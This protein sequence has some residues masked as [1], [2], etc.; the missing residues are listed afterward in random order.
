MP[1]L[2]TK[3]DAGHQEYVNWDPVDPFFI[4]D[5]E[6]RYRLITA[7]SRERETQRN[8]ITQVFN[9]GLGHTAFCTTDG[10]GRGALVHIKL[11]TPSE[12]SVNL[13]ELPENT[14]VKFQ[15][16]QQDRTYEEGD[17]LMK[18]RL[19]EVESSADLVIATESFGTEVKPS[20]NFQIVTVVQP[21]TM[22][23]DDQLNALNEVTN[24]TVY[25]SPYYFVLDFKSVS[26]LESHLQEER[27]GHIRRLFPLD[28]VQLQAFVNSTSRVTCGVSLNQGPPGTGKTRTAVAIILALT[29]L[30]IKV[31]V[32]A[33]SNK[34]VDNLLESLVTAA[35][36]DAL[37]RAWCDQFVR[38]G[39]PAYQ[40]SQIRA[41]S[42]SDPIARLRAQADATNDNQANP[43]L[44][45]VQAHNLV[46]AHAQQNPDDKH[47]KS[48]LEYMAIDKEKGLSRDGTKK[49]RSSYENT[50]L[51][52]FEGCIVVATTL[53]N[54]SH[55][56]LR[57]PNF[58][59]AFIVSDEAGQCLEGDHC[60]A[61]TM[62]SV[63][64]VVLIGDPDQ[65]SPTTNYRNHSQILDLFNSGMYRG[66]LVPGPEND[67]LERV[68]RAWDSFTGPR[69][70]F[71]ALNVHG[72]RRLFISIIGK[73]KRME[74]SLPWSN[75][76]QV[77][78]LHHLLTSL[79][80]FQTSNGDSVLPEDVMIV[81]PYKDQ[82]VLVQRILS[83]HEV[84]YRDNLTVD[85]TQGQE[86]PIVMFLMTKP[87]QNV[88][89]AG[90]MADTNRLNIV[91]SRAKKVMI[92]IGNL[93]D[94]NNNGI[95]KMKQ[96]VGKR[97]RFLID[98]IRDVTARRHTLTW[99]G[100]EANPTGRVQYFS[101][102][103]PGD[104]QDVPSGPSVVAPPTVR[105]APFAPPTTTLPVV[106]TRDPTEVAELLRTQTEEDHYVDMGDAPRVLA[107]N[108]RYTVQLPLRQRSCSP[109]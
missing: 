15:V 85:A 20:V 70:W 105:P 4:D 30:R 13:P 22:P 84:R 52:Y 94:W 45:K 96:S 80:L 27:L 38:F 89:S 5:S 59:P 47:C 66:K 44:E 49:L 9:P 21:N 48:L 106:Q 36:R 56:V 92:I 76:S 7:S 93:R 42:A 39:T 2:W 64:G 6:R 60:I 78:V 34:T 71:R 29:A 55:D 18:G 28:D 24:V 99:A 17:L 91:L 43:T 35:A 65:L 57:L 72:M 54:A 77:Q 82:K 14:E 19:V 68:G 40:L 61:L 12:N 108:V 58:K 98:L 73:A 50:L 90:F 10:I 37:L 109:V 16:A 87:S 33:G 46:V 11:C 63:R 3:P 75:E 41:K 86:A 97:A 88:A 25:E 8:V 104:I 95:A 23:I 101:H 103:R 100:P 81:S 69:H 31:L 79:Y 62:P 32:V 26:P 51:G 107:P 67:R 53:S 102:D 83:Q 74:N 1:W